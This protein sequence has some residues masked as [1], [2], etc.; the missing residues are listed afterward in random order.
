MQRLL[1]NLV[2]NGNWRLCA[3]VNRMLLNPVF[4]CTFPVLRRV[5]LGLVDDVI[6]R[7][8]AQEIVNLLF[9][10]APWLVFTSEKS[11]PQEFEFLRVMLRRQT[12]LLWLV[13]ALHVVK[14]LLDLL[15]LLF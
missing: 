2:E 12:D 4:H 7:V 13:Q 9:A 5:I 10:F 14:L 11:E 8:C 6:E 15:R 3:H 1:L